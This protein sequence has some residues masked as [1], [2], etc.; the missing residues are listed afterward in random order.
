M[1]AEIDPHPR[2][3]ASSTSPGCRSVR[4]GPRGR[5]RRGD[6]SGE[7][8][9][10]ADGQRRRVPAEQAAEPGDARRAG[11][12]GE[13]RRRRARAASPPVGDDHRRGRRAGAARSSRCSA[14]STVVPRSAFRRATRG[15]HVVGALRVELRRRLVEHEHARRRPRARRRWRTA[16]A[17]RP[18]AWPGSGRGGGRCRARRAPPRP[19]GAWPPGPMPRFSSTKARSRLDVVDDELRLGV[20]VHEARRR[21]PADA[22]GAS[23]VDRPATTT[24]PANRPPRRVGHQAVRRSAAACS[25]PSRTRP[26]TRSTS[27][28]VDLEVDA[29]RARAPRPGRRSRTPRN[30]TA[31]CIPHQRRDGEQAHRDHG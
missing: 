27:P 31:S 15:E 7:P 26:T 10:V 3:A 16:G 4:L 12:A 24:S 6:R 1:P 17:R 23:R 5:G 30:V 2:R 21:R 13:R 8:A 22:A 19:G 25:C 9:R 28:A 20:L 14:S 18:T 11:V 29:D